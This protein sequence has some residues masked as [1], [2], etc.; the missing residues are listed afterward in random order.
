[1]KRIKL[2][3]LAAALLAVF[4]LAGCGGA[5][6]GA[7]AGAS[8]LRSTFNRTG[9]P[10][11]TEPVTVTFAFSPIT[12]TGDPERL[13]M[14]NTIAGITNITVNWMR[15]ENEQVDVFIAAGDL[16]DL[17]YDFGTAHR[18][19]L[20]GVEA[21]LFND[22]TNYLEFMPNLSWMFDDD[23]FTRKIVTEFNGEIYALPMKNIG[24]TSAT[25]RLKIRTDYLARLGLDMPGT[26]DEFY[27]VLRRALDQGL[28]GGFE[29]LISYDFGGF[30]GRLE[31][32]LFASFGDSADVGWAADSSNRVVY[33]RISEQYR[34]Y[35][36]YMNRLYSEGLF[37]REY[38]TM[39]R[40][41][42]DARE[43]NGQAMV[44]TQFMI[45][46]PEHFADGEVHLDQIKPLTSQ[47]TNT[48]KTQMY[49][50]YRFAGG[51]M[52]AS[53]EYPHE[54]ARYIDMW[55]SRTDI[56][57]NSGIFSDSFV[58][59]IYGRDF[60][61]EDDSGENRLGQYMIQ[62]VPSNINMPHGAYLT[63]HVKP[64]HR[65][66]YYDNL[67]VGGTPNS[68]ARQLG[69]VRNNI[70]YQVPY[71]PIR[72]MK[73]TESEMTTI[74]AWAVDIDTYAREMRARF[75]AGISNINDDSEWN[76]YVNTIQ[77]MRYEDVRGAYQ[78]AYDRWVS[79]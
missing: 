16:P 55:F 77:G 37:N 56:V 52:S 66:G 17:L 48:R 57:P 61:Y 29:P 76:S 54:I 6:P 23:P 33:N 10:I 35:I 4:S 63:H 73:L 69:Y 11:S 59:G 2:L 8:Q 5:R 3:F 15:L 28:T 12:I 19:H 67:V 72:E 44:S 42:A 41:T 27:T 30:N 50:H 78:S 68:L 32:F 60:W 22:W 43:L 53:T 21:G 31:P 9:Y 70:P 47:F 46:N 79:Y 45:L 71:F 24:S 1:M 75:I 13:D 20:Y 39:D 74:Q 18:L 36:R 38:M 65:F 26:V 49:D 7:G 34:H 14:M 64:T 40:P 25:T 62:V 51:M 58:Y